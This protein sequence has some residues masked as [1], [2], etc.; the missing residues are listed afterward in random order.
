MESEWE[1][2][3]CHKAYLTSDTLPAVMGVVSSLMDTTRPVT[4]Y[5]IPSRP[6]VE[7]I[8]SAPVVEICCFSNMP[9]T[10]EEKLAPFDEELKKSKG[11][12]GVVNGWKIEEEGGK[13]FVDLIGW[14]ATEAHVQAVTTGRLAEEYFPPP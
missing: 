7:K 11:L 3:D 9:S 5:H 6:E 12:W 2:L 8:L 13:E 14:D 10:F 4:S 1:N